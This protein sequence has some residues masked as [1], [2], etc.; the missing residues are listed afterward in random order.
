LVSAGR[1]ATYAVLELAGADGDARQHAL[2]QIE[3][4]L[5]APGQA[6]RPPLGPL[7]APRPPPATSPSRTAAPARTRPP[8][9][10]A[11]A[12]AAPPPRR[13]RAAPPDQLPAP[14]VIPHPARKGVS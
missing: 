13:P 9:R 1:H 10:P 7:R 2:A 11:H 5:A 12:R 6:A 8:G 14:A 4:G 3:G